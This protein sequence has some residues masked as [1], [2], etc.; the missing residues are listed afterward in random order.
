[1]II[2]LQPHLPKAEVFYTLLRNPGIILIRILEAELRIYLD[3]AALF[4]LRDFVV[5]VLCK[6]GMTPYEAP[7][8]LTVNDESRRS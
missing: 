2:F 8:K 5:F 4:V 1:M 7:L 3:L 6:L